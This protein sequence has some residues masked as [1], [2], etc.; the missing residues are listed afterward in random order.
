MVTLPGW[1]KTRYAWAKRWDRRMQM[2]QVRWIQWR[3]SRAFYRKH[4]K[5]VKV[6]DMPRQRDSSTTRYADRL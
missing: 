6:E 2:V 5:V 3:E 4:G 1:L